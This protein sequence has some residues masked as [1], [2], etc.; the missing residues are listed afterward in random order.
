MLDSFRTA[1]G[2]NIN[3]PDITIGRLLLRISIGIH[4]SAAPGPNDGV[5]VAVAT[6]DKDDISGGTGTIS[7]PV[8]SPYDLDYMWWEQLYYSEQLM[9]GLLKPTAAVDTILYRS[10]DIRS[11]RKLRGMG[12]TLVVQTVATGNATI[13]GTS[14]TGQVLMLLPK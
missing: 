13:T 10:L 6:S 4:I 1:F 2:I 8:A 14:I 5:L 9:Q 11:M 3:L 12:E 7:S